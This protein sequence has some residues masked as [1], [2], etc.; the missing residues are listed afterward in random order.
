MLS[1][2]LEEILLG[3]YNHLHRGNYSVAW[4][5]IIHIYRCWMAWLM[6]WRMC[7]RCWCWCNSGVMVFLHNE[8]KSLDD[9]LDLDFAWVLRLICVPFIIWLASHF[10]YQLWLKLITCQLMTSTRLPWS[11]D[12]QVYATRQDSTLLYSNKRAIGLRAMS[13]HE[14]NLVVLTVL[15]LSSS[16][17]CL[18]HLISSSF[19]PVVSFPHHSVSLLLYTFYSQSMEVST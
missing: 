9:D 5:R 18:L 7:G 8:T 1:K 10:W 17:S 13:S 19:L 4:C 11:N 3:R 16:E 12:R 15:P 6:W 2:S 14:V